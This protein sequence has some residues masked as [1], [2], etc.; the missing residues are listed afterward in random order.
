MGRLFGVRGTAFRSFE[1]P[2]MWGR[3]EGPTWR[4][5]PDDRP[6]RAPPPLSFDAAACSDS[7]SPPLPRPHPLRRPR[8]PALQVPPANNRSYGRVAGHSSLC[9]TMGCVAAKGAVDSDTRNWSE[10]KDSP[11]SS[12]E[13]LG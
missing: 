5:R 13:I 1:G 6:N 10:V 4:G 2:N 9:T 12:A 8:S 11:L 3:G 7:T